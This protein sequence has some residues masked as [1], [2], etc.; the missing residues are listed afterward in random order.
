M[1]LRNS[2][3]TTEGYLEEAFKLLPASVSVNP[4]DG[5]VAEYKEY[6]TQNEFELALDELEHLGEVNKLSIE[7]WENLLNAAK[8]M[9]LAKHEKRY[10]EILGAFGEG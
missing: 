4:E 7:Y 5:S 8:E 10:L 2:W 6:I 9:G 1:N 3:Q